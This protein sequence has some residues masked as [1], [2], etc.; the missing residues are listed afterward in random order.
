MRGCSGHQHHRASLV[1]LRLLAAFPLHV[2]TR[3]RPPRPQI[4]NHPSLLF[5]QQHHLSKILLILT[6]D[7]LPGPRP[8]NSPGQNRRAAAA[9]RATETRARNQALR[10]HLSRLASILLTT[11][12]SPDRIGPKGG[13]TDAGVRF[14]WII[15]S[16]AAENLL[17][18]PFREWPRD[19]LARISA[20]TEAGEIGVYVVSFSRRRIRLCASSRVCLMRRLIKVWKPT[21]RNQLSSCRTRRQRDARY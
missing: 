16:P 10:S 12:V 1:S 3:L 4:L 21:G 14:Q 8:P 18:T 20:I 11:T 15:A 5:L 7:V 6:M 19:G 9:A 13:M 2:P 17:K